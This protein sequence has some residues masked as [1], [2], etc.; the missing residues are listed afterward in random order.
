MDDTKK[1]TPVVDVTPTTTTTEE[2]KNKGGSK[3]LTQEEVNNLV[4]QI[5]RESKEKTEKDIQ[6]AVSTAISEYERKARLTQEQKDAEEKQKRQA[7]IDKRERDLTLRERK[8]EAKDML[9]QKNI[10]TELVDFVVDLDEAKTKENIEKLAKTFNKSVE[11]GVTSKLKGTPI[12]DFSNS[13]PNAGS[14]AKKIT[15]AF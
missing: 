9:I 7:E 1:T 15:T 2:D 5:K 14:G 6:D 4:S 10:P 8:I 3:L 12:E 13:T 11:D